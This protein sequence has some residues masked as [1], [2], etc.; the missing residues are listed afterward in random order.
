MKKRCPAKT[1]WPLLVLSCLLLVACGERDSRLVKEAR[2]LYGKRIV[3]P[4]E[5]ESISYSGIPNVGN[6]IAKK[7]KI[8]TY[9]DSISCGD[10]AFRL[11]KEWDKLL[12]DIPAT[13]D[14]GFIPVIYPS[15]REEIRRLLGLF[16]IEWPLLYDIRDE[17]LTKNK[18]EVLARNKTFLLD[19]KNRIIVIGEPLNAPALWSVY[20]KAMGI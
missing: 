11:V 7:F 4:S 18:L 14:V 12:K 1:I 10:C 19:E 3:L 8:A 15:D 9:I 5:Y 16:E 6:E 2:S 17:F 20:K 13:A